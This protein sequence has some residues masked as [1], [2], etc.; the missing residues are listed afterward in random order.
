[1][2]LVLCSTAG[3][4]YIV[5]LIVPAG[6]P[7]VLSHAILTFPSRVKT[8]NDPLWQEDGAI[9]QDNPCHATDRGKRM[10]TLHTL[11]AF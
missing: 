3:G 6:P 10:Q 7:E 9:F 1:M 11:E 5:E 2:R 8:M 4:C